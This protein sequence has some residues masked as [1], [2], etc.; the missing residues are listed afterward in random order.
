MHFLRYQEYYEGSEE[1]KGQIFTIFDYMEWYAKS[2]STHKT[3]K[4]K[5]TQVFTYPGDWSGF[6]VPSYVFEELTPSTI[7]DSSRYDEFM[8]NI[9]LLAIGIEKR[10]KWY[11]IG[12]SSDLGSPSGLKNEDVLAHEIAHGFYYTNDQYRN[13]VNELYEKVP[14]EVR[15]KLQKW[16]LK[17]GYCQDVVLDETHAYLATGLPDELRKHEACKKARRPFIREFKRLKKALDES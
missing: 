7:P 4:G 12:T 14:V 13:A 15:D 16:L 6:N 5:K 17:I 2:S 3:R 8:R 9:A 1:F 11:L 10:E